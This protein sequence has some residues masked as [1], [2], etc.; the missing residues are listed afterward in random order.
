M[1]VRSIKK[2]LER[3]EAAQA[4]RNVACCRSAIIETGRSHKGESHLVLL[5]P[6]G[7]AHC[8]FKQVPGP[9]PQLADFG[10]FGWVNWFTSAEMKM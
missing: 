4:K 5:S 3:L 10:E 6:P 1:A 8:V 2:R 9:G 7:E